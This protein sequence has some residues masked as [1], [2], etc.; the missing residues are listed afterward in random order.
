M[1]FQ[2]VLRALSPLLLQAL[3]TAVQLPKKMSSQRGAMMMMIVTAAD[4]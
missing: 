4:A 1:T 2:Q 3:I